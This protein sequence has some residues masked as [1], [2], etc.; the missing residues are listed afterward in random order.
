MFTQLLPNSGA[1]P[2]VDG[3]ERF[4]VSWTGIWPQA[5]EWFGLA[6]GC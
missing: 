3:L 6:K 5:A 4:I 1:L 2:D